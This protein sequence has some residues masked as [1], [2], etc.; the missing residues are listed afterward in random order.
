MAAQSTSSK[1]N[2]NGKSS[3]SESETAETENASAE[4]A[5]VDEL[6]DQ[7]EKIRA[8]IGDLTKIIS[9]LAGD[10]AKEL[11]SA[12]TG[13]L[14]DA[15]AQGR[16]AVARAEDQFASL[17]RDAE[18]YVRRN[19]VQALAMAAGFGIVLGWLSRR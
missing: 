2:G 8:D 7:I 5:S 11:R 13:R 15:E 9:D 17:N 10:K 3:A 14:A 1:S 18:A 4:N 16:D 6:S 12:V 19:P